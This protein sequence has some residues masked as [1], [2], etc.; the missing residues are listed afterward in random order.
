VTRG[1]RGPEH[2]ARPL[3]IVLAVVALAGAGV[4]LATVLHPRSRSS[5]TSTTSTTPRGPVQATPGW[6]VITRTA[7]GVAVDQRWFAVPGGARVYVLR[8]RKGTVAFHF[9]V[10][11]EDPPGANLAVPLDARSFISAWEWR[12]GVVGVFNGGFKRNAR[13]GGTVVDGY[14]AVPLRLGAPTLVIDARGQMALGTW[15]HGVPAGGQPVVAAR[16]NL[17]YLVDRGAVTRLAPHLAA[18]GSTLGGANAVARTGLGLNR[19]GDVL[20][21]VGAPILPIDLARALVAAGAVR[22]IELDI[23]PYWPISGASRVPLHAPSGFRFTSP[24]S[25]HSPTIYESSWL[26][27]FFVVVAEPPPARCRVT[28]PVPVARDVDAE[29]LSIACTP[30]R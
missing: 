24:Y 11:S 20:Y 5:T 29:R 15:G 4:A 22:A 10:G 25:E 12:V 16:Q 26:R 9:H 19:A 6:G 13:A 8:F 2:R 28:S 23:N 17:G 14:V 27:D 3:A 18:W 30:R 7:R 1:A 21:A